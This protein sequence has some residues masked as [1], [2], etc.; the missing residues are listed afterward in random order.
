MKN[1]ACFPSASAL[2]PIG[3]PRGSH[4]APHVSHGA[5]Y[6]APM[7]LPNGLHGAPIGAPIGTPN[8]FTLTLQKQQKRKHLVVEYKSVSN[9]RLSYQVQNANDSTAKLRY[10]HAKPASSWLTLCPTLLPHVRKKL[11]FFAAYFRCIKQ[12]F[13]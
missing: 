5:P 7:A 1:A 4:G 8:G 2:A 6:G 9:F 12:Q 3:A 11:P 13:S 10:I